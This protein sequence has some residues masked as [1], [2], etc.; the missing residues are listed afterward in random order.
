MSSEEIVPDL[1]VKSASSTNILTRFPS[2]LLETSVDP[3]N[4]SK[5]V[6]RSDAS[7]QPKKGNH[8][9]IDAL[10]S[11]TDLE[12]LDPI[13]AGLKNKTGGGEALEG[14]KECKENSEDAIENK[15]IHINSSTLESL[16][17]NLVIKTVKKETSL[18]VTE[19][20]QN[21]TNET[22]IMNTNMETEM[23][24]DISA[25]VATVEN[26]K[27]EEKTTVPFHPSTPVHL[28]FILHL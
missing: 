20:D 11:S 2:D 3:D 16:D 14:D 17:N 7:N 5:G 26:S 12:S 13:T 6:L 22:D 25:N 24:Q 18:R 27:S 4:E 8:S 23:I 10:S 9:K 19:N 1:T 28:N 21:D 15:I